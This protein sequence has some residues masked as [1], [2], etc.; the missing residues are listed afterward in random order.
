MEGVGHSRLLELLWREE[1]R[2]RGGVEGGGE[3][4]EEG[5]VKEREERGEEK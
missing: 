3:M 1:R 5:Y 2:R 4:E